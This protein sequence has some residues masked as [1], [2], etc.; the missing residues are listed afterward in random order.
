MKL[1]LTH[2]PRFAVPGGKGA[3]TIECLYK[4]DVFVTLNLNVPIKRQ[5]EKTRKFLE[6]ERKEQRIKAIEKNHQPSLFPCYWRLL[7]AEAEQKNRTQIAK[8]LYG[9]R[10][11][12]RNNEK[13]KEQVKIALL[14][15]D[16]DYIFL[17]D[18]P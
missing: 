9:D 5:L 7:D 11:D 1:A 16:S 6:R 4:G 17:A 2:A 14:L 3:A 12:Y 15:R 8:Y 13:I 18:T 10:R